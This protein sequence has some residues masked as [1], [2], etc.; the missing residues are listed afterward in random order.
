[1]RD[2]DDDDENGESTCPM[3]QRPW[4]ACLCEEDFWW[5]EEEARHELK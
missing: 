5:D 2:D 4:Y 1:M 3:C